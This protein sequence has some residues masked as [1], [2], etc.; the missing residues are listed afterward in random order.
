MGNKDIKNIIAEAV[1]R[2]ISSYDSKLL[3]KYDAKVLEK[4]KMG[5]YTL[6]LVYIEGFYSIALSRNNKSFVTPNVQN[7]KIVPTQPS[8][9]PLRTFLMKIIGWCDKY[10]KLMLGSYNL[11]KQQKYINI[12]EKSGIFEIIPIHKH[13]IFIK[14]KKPQ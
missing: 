12:I 10:G 14:N 2:E 8:S 6:S 4:E 5:D 7:R 3:K 9:L 11:D 13:A 1:M